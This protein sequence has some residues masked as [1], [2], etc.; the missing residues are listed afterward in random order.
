MEARR[1]PLR[2]RDVPTRGRARRRGIFVTMLVSLAVLG[3]A[4]SPAVA[5]VVDRQDLGPYN[6][7]VDA[8]NASDRE[9]QTF[10]AG[11]SGFLTAVGMPITLHNAAAGDLVVTITGLTGAGKPD[12][13]NVLVSQTFP[14]AAVAGDPLVDDRLAFS[15]PPVITA[16]T[17]YAI[18][19]SSTAGSLACGDGQCP[20][21]S[22][23]VLTSAGTAYQAGVVCGDVGGGFSCSN[24]IDML[25]KTYVR[26][27]QLDGFAEPISNSARN[28][29]QAGRTVPVK[30]H[31]TDSS[32]API[33]DPAHFVSG[34]VGR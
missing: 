19:L 6:G 24:G 21:E 18:V 34:V 12:P 14:A 22:Y 4:S 32:G 16:G 26:E 23:F 25:F 9:A 28:V 15:S 20:G 7:V 33:S 30:W 10:V 27:F 13:S 1:S 17:G 11:R 5:D 8:F 2:R 3:A 29:A 31:V